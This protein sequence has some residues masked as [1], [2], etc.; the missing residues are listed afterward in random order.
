MKI[1][2]AIYHCKRI[3]GDTDDI[4]Q[5]APPK[6]HILKLG[7]ITVQ[8]ATGYSSVI[9]YGAKISGTWI[10]IAN[11]NEYHGVF[12]AGDLM[13]IEGNAPKTGDVPGK[14]ANAVIDHVFKQNKVLRIVLREY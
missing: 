3:S 8:P 13:Y 10:M 14:G 2:E 9:L 1:G 12:K 11:A 6:R 4:R 7:H 5:Y